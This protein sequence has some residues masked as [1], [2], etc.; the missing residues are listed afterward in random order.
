MLF[1]GRLPVRVAEDLRMQCVSYLTPPHGPFRA[2]VGLRVRLI[3]GIFLCVGVYRCPER[4]VA[5][6]L[7]GEVE[8]HEPSKIGKV[9]H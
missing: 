6:F 4:E 3:A 9:G 5:A 2:P 7:F 1:G 8:R